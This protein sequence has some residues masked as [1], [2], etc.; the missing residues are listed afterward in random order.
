M[1]VSHPQIMY[2]NCCYLTSQLL[3]AHIVYGWTLVPK[4]ISRFTANNNFLKLGGT[5]PPDHNPRLVNCQ[6]SPNYY[7]LIQ[8][9][10]FFQ[11]ST[12]CFL[13]I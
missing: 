5:P 12:L 11:A 4:D 10:L 3:G 7:L 13:Q 6:L 2:L 9:M 1:L 8:S